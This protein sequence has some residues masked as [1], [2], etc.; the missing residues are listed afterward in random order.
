MCGRYRRRSD[1]QRIAETFHVESGLDEV[2]FSADD[3]AAPGTFQPVVYMDTDGG[4]KISLMYWGF[5]LPERLV[6]DARSDT[7]AKNSLWKGALQDQRCI[8]P[9]DSILEWKHLYKN[10]KKNPKYE[11]TIPGQ[12]PLGMAAIWRPWKHPKT[13][14]VVPTMAIITTDPN[15][16]WAE[17]HERQTAILE[18]REYREWLTPSER[19]PLHLV[20]TMPGDE[21][22]IHLVGGQDLQLPLIGG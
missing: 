21:M 14:N 16:Q 7:L 6:F 3:N 15:E 4:P 19:P 1:K 10:T 20:R 13:G 18:P 11:I 8:V 12:Q 2:E 22:E 9:A 17:V 5:Q